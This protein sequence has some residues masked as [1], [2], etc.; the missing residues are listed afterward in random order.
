MSTR[1]NTKLSTVNKS[2]DEPS[3]FIN[4]QL[5][6]SIK[7]K[8]EHTHE[9]REKKTVLTV[10]AEPVRLTPKQKAFAD[11]ML[12]N[13]KASA[14]EAVKHAY[15]IT[16]PD[17][18]TARSIATENQAKPSIQAYLNEHLELARKTNLEIMKNA[19][20]K[21]DNV[22]FQELAHSVAESIYDRAIGKPVTRGISQNIRSIESLVE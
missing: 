10:N 6:A 14:T 15:N 13:P 20:K 3:R 21:K 22:R 18:S 7:N 5:K 16:N 4:R 2:T 9:I 1:N 8:K 11:Y 12:E 17:S 19:S